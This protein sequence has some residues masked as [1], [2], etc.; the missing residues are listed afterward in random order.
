MKLVRKQLDLQGRSDHTQPSSDYANS[1]QNATSSTQKRPGSNK[2]SNGI[3]G[4]NKKA[5][6]ILRLLYHEKKDLL[7]SACED[8]NIY[9]WGFDEDQIKA[10]SQMAKTS[11]KLAS[12]LAAGDSDDV[13]N[14]VAGFI[15]QWAGAFDAESLT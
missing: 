13:T 2:S 5:R 1:K 7:I 8:H 6:T 10:Y 3:K 15:C 11:K 14:R 4:F 9:I 12:N